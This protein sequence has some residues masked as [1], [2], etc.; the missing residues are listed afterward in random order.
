MV[1]KKMVDMKIKTPNCCGR[2]MEFKAGFPGGGFSHSW[3]AFQCEKCGRIK[4]ILGN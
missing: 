4:Q 1:M 2:P 3:Y